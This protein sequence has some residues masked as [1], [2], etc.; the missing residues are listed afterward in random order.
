MKKEKHAIRYGI[1]FAGVVFFV[2][3][4]VLLM[5]GSNRAAD[6]ADPR[7]LLVEAHWPAYGGDLGGSQY[8]PLS[9]INRD[10]VRQLQVA[11]TIRTGDMRHEGQSG[12]EGTCSKCHASDSKFETTPILG[13]NRLY[14]STPT[15][16]TLALNPET[17]AEEWAYDPKIDLSLNRNEG[18]ISRGVSQW[19]D[20]TRPP[21]TPCRHT[22]FL[23]TVDA[24]LI[25]L[26]A[27]TGAL[28]PDFG[29]AG[30]VRLDEG[31][32]DLQE[33]Q[34]GVTSPPAII[35]DVVVVGSSVGDNRR[36]DDERGIVRAF[37]ARTGTMVWSWDPIPRQPGM[38]G[39][40]TWTPEGASKTGAANAW[41]PLSGDEERDLVFIPTGSASP[42]FYGGERLGSNLFANS[43]VALRASTGERVWH[44]QVVHH[45]LWDY[46]VPAQPTLITVPRD[47]EDIPAVAVATKMGHLFV[48]HRE[49]GEPLFPVEE[50]PVPASTVPG[51]EAWPTQPFPVLPRPL[52]PQTLGPDDAWGLTEED[53][54]YCR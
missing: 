8:S 24:R 36:V 51:E 12:G 53:R 30:T 47:G 41:A 2:T 28:C 49:T 26:D 40:E 6:P 29:E 38:P 43:V 7:S 52:H 31:I 1:S 5:T 27:A 44:Y 33:G 13:G 17:G 11:W 20:P 14:V 9:Q 10:N 37:D 18:F 23:A 32:G 50:R 54:T 39:W 25:A 16:R 19:E 21:G 45:D 48:L 3:G 4:G 42:D 35:G 15:N 46:D 34:Y 22:V